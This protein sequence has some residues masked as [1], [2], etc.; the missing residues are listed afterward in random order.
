[1]ASSATGDHFHSINTPSYCAFKYNGQHLRS[2]NNAVTLQVP[3]QRA[4]PFSQC[5]DQ[6]VIYAGLPEQ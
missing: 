5:R 1:M 4:T 2:I 6:Y 3:M